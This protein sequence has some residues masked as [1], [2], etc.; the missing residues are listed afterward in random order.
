MEGAQE[1]IVEDMLVTHRKN[2]KT[3]PIYSSY[4]LPPEPKR[5]DLPLPDSR[6]FVLRNLLSQEEA[7]VTFPQLH[8]T[9]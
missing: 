4:S 1:V 5:E 6:C 9:D 7:L 2:F 3:V 8:P